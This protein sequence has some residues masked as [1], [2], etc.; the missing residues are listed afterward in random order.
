MNSMKPPG[1]EDPVGRARLLH[2]RL[3]L[4]TACLLQSALA[5]LDELGEHLAACH[6]SLAIDSLRSSMC[7]DQNGSL[8]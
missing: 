2:N 6:L 1:D 5:N 3:Q 8:G 4:E 7:P